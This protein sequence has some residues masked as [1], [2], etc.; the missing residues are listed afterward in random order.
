MSSLNVYDKPLKKCCSDPVT[1]FYR[2]GYCSTGENDIG[3]HVTCAVL[4]DEFL[5]FSASKGNDLKTPR[6]QFSFPGLKAGDR[7]CLCSSRWL[8]ALEAGV[9]PKIDLDATHIKLLEFVDVEVLE[10]YK[11]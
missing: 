5:D 3:L 2:D 7:W 9:A 6:P 10:K 1:G 4:T 8:E 11:I